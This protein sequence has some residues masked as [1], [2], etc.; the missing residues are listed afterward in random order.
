ML[1]SEPSLAMLG[2]L[3]LLRVE[4]EEEEEE[5]GENQAGWFCL[6]CKNS[7]E[8]PRCKIGAVGR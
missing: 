4:K 3:T 1:K 7:A 5:E 2:S 6:W 8:G